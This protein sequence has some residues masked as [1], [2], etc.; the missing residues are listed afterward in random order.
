MPT[1]Q[2]LTPEQFRKELAGLTDHRS[3]AVFSTDSFRDHATNLAVA[4]GIVFNRKSLDAKT[5][6]TRIDSAIQTGITAANG[7]D[8][9]A[10]LNAACEHVVASPNAVV[11]PEF[12]G[13]VMPI[14]SMDEDEAYAFVR[15]LAKSRY[16]IVAF[17]KR[18]W[19]ERKDLRA[20]VARIEKETAE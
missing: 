6:W 20:A 8:L 9:H 16:T 19:D 11:S 14:L 7:A 13:L 17:A 5:L 2:A 1:L 12:E 3:S 4:L 10:L 15:H 18:A